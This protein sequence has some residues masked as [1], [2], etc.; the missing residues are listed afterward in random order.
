MALI[1]KE[2]VFGK[3]ALQVQ[4]GAAGVTIKT[5]RQMLLRLNR[6]KLRNLHHL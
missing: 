2:L 4:T 1:L 5:L 6:N 3:I